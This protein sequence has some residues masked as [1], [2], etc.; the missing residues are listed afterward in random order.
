MEGLNNK[1][2]TIHRFPIFF[3]IY[4][5]A[6]TV[7]MVFWL[8]QIP[9]SSRFLKT[10]REKGA[11]CQ[12][13]PTVVF[14]HVVVVVFEKKKPSQ[15]GKMRGTQPGSPNKANSHGSRHPTPIPC[16]LIVKKIII[17]LSIECILSRRFYGNKSSRDHRRED[18]ILC[19]G[20][21]RVYFYFFSSSFLLAQSA[22][23][24]CSAALCVDP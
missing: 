11:Q 6:E 7:A 8:H 9:R 20:L 4:P 3:F 2:I 23:Q 17:I 1:T 16:C 15:R 5:A 19:N 22:V 24:Q 10:A 12:H 21:K 13:T 18:I 14:I